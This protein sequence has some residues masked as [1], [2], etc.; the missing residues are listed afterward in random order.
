MPNLNANRVTIYA[1]EKD[2]KKFLLSAQRDDWTL[3]WLFNMHR[4]FP[5][6]FG[7]DD[8]A[9]FKNQDTCWMI[10]HTWSKWYPT[11]DITPTPD[12]VLLTYNTAWTPNNFALL[13]LSELTGW[14]I[15]N[16]Y[17]V[18]GSWDQGICI[19]EKGAVIV[20]ELHEYKRCHFCDWL[21]PR[22]KIKKDCIEDWTRICKP[23]QKGRLKR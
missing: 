22:A 23:C 11:I 16:N 21:Y 17:E 15:Q 9:G 8:L 5:E 10:L 18:E 14:R 13:K 1:P 4:L 3:Y 19:M 7:E 2:V 6:R 12:G 20:D